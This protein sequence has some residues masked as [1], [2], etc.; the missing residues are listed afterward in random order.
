MGSGT[1]EG[2]A[3]QVIEELETFSKIWTYCSAMNVLA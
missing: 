2:G 3:P 1:F